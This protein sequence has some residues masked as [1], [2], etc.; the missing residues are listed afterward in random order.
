V[1][2]RTKWRRQNHAHQHS[3]PIVNHRQVIAVEDINV[4]RMV[5]NHCL[6]KS[7]HDAGL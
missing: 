2:E 6:A 4:S 3:R 7:F 5:H 1:H